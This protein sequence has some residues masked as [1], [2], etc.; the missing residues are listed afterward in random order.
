[1]IITVFGGSNPR[2]GDPA[3]QEAYHLGELIGKA[4]HTVMTGGYMGTMEAVS[5]GCNEHGGHVIGVSCEELENWRPAKVN[6]WV[7]EEV[8]LPTLIG[9]LEYL[10]R[11]CNAAIAL[12]GGAGTLAEIA[13]MWNLMI[14]DVVPSKPLA[15]IGKGWK[16]T[17]AVYRKELGNYVPDHDWNRMQ[18][19]PEPETAL[20]YIQQ[21]VKEQ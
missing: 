12:P 2:P 16:E 18:F 3:Y 19:L 20:A 4:G 7:K 10:I 9:R 14:I 8:C 21:T 17:M 11:R 15:L 13:V 1:M 6:P 5:K